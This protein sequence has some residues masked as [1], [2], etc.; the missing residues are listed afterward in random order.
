MVRPWA[1][2]A[3]IYTTGVLHTKVP[4]AFLGEAARRITDLNPVIWFFHSLLS[5]YHK[6]P[7]IFVRDLK[8]AR[9]LAT[10]TRLPAS[11][12]HCRSWRH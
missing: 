12:P 1:Q 2:I 7:I 9:R 8:I 3:K 4:A 5:L 6:R 11:A 10:S